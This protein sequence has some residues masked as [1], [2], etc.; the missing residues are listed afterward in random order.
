MG[1]QVLDELLARYTAMPP[2]DQA[3]VKDSLV[4]GTA[5][6]R[7]IPNPGPQEDAYFSKADVLLFGGEPGGGKTQLLIGWALNESQRALI[8]RRQYTDLG[9]VIESAL[10]IHGSRDGYN[11]TPPPSLTHATGFIEFGAAARIGDEQRHMGK[12]KDFLGLDEGTQFAQKQIRFLRAWIRTDKPGQRC[13]TIIATNPPLTA[14]GAWV[15]EMFAP[16]LNPRFP[17]P[18]EPGELRWVVV[19]EDDNDHWVE[20]PGTYDLGGGVIREAE[21]RTYIPSSLKD[22][23]AYDVKEY[24][25]RLDALPAEIREILL[26]GFMTTFRDHPFQVIPTAWVQAAF[27]R[28]K[29]GRPPGIPMTG[30]GVDPSG[31][32]ADDL[33]IAPRH[34]WYFDEIVTVPGSKLDKMKMG[35][36]QAGYV[37]Q[38]RK[39]GAKIGLDMGGG[40][41]Q[42][43][44]ETMLGNL[45]PKEIVPLKGAEKSV[46]RTK[47]GKMGFHNQ[48]AERIW[49]FR[50]ALDPDQDGGS[51][52]ALPEDLELLA[53]LTAVTYEVTPRGYKVTPKDSEGENADCVRSRL[54][55]SPN[56]GDAVLNSWAVGD[57]LIPKGSK[58]TRQGRHTTPGVNLGPRHRRPQR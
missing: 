46:A 45:D 33:A 16:W 47:D 38:N 17:N 40:Y 23:P 22:N 1:V 58:Y 51:P 7:W 30:I 31:G 52:I 56:K 14:D 3:A 25:K 50:E 44:Y 35:S 37:L 19:D 29:E 39:D 42:A 13:R 54:G 34:D 27:E 11:G 28:H 57:R 4:K 41:G 10:K 24:Q 26:G 53:D 32:G 55:R 8:A 36:Q 12:P 5:G 18:A 6:Y 20:G 49:K 15:V 9:F 2:E 48:R 43:I 21:S